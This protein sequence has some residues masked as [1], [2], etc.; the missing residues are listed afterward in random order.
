[1]LITKDDLTKIKR[2]L[3]DELAPVPEKLLVDKENDG[4]F[5][6]NEKFT[7]IGEQL[8]KLKQKNKPAPKTNPK[9]KK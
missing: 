7:V 3:D 2:N 6:V 4:F 8:P 1:M 5:N 9:Q